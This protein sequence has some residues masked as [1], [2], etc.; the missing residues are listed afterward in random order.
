MDFCNFRLPLLILAA[1]GCCSEGS[2]L[3]KA[4]TNGVIGKNVTFK[5]TITSTQ[6]FLT[7]TWNFNK[8]PVIAPIITSVLVTNTDNID[9]K[10]TSRIIYNNAT[11]ELQLGP[12]VKEDEGEYILNIVTTK[13][14]QL[15][16]QIDL[17]VLEPVT[18]VKISSNL[19]EA[20]E[21]NSTVVLS[22]SAKGSFTYEWLNGSV[23]L[24]VDGTHMKLNAVGDELTI[25]EV[26]RTD[27]R[28]PIV[29]IAENALES[30]RSAPFNL[31]VCYG[32][33]KVIMTQTPTD[34]FLKNG[35]NLTLACSAQSD[36]PA[37]LQWMFNGEEMPQKT[38]ANI[39]LT[40]VEGKHSG[41]YS[42]VAYNA[43]TNRYVSSQVAVVSVLEALSGTNISSSSSLLIAGNSTVNITCSAAGGKAESVGWL[44]ESKPVT[45]SDRIILSADKKTLT[46]VKVVKEDA[47]N[48]KCQLK[49]KV[50]KDESTYVMVINYGP[51]SV[52]VKGKNAVKFEEPAE[53]KCLADSFPPSIFSWKLNG[54]AMNHSRADIIIDKAKVTD[55]GTYTC[56]AFNPITRM[57]KTT[58]HKLAV[59]EVGAVDE[60]LSGG[61]IAGIVIGVLV[62][63]IIIACIIKR[64]KKS[65]TDI[66][67]PY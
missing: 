26:R 48:Y 6:D 64:K 5:T 59:T 36:P 62:A 42:C 54:T 9:E 1:L 47:G 27:L 13:G 50:N 49:N 65:S 17:E 38:T 16:G 11:C 30:G 34:S 56:E 52:N 24:V 46:I 23:P 60:G 37:Q 10:Y 4:K 55:S 57:M 8:D 33:E 32:P 15:S 14:Q 44:K 21:F 25:A 19:P 2:P 12:L 22:C 31:T 53:L 61:A 67:S 51:E 63:V 39:T 41:N 18:D 40:N 7:V 45:S 28:G 35:S 43:K 20:V 3:L 29:C 66:P 58:T